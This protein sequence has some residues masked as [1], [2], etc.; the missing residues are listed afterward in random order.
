MKSINKNYLS[1][2][3]RKLLFENT[4]KINLPVD[5]GMYANNSRMTMYDRPGPN[6]KNSEDYE[7]SYEEDDDIELPLTASDVVSNQ[8]LIQVNFD[9][10]D[11]DFLPDNKTE[12]SSALSACLSKVGNN[13][14]T[15]K[16]IHKV[17]KSFTEILEKAK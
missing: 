1:E 13:D 4:A 9:P 17:W 11:R 8:A 10:H 15:K 16:E 12:L 3:A 5:D 6:I 7:K 14:L 2:L